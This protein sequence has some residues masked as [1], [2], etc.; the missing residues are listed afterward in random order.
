MDD[1]PIEAEVPA[2]MPVRMLNEF[3]YCPRLCFIEWVA[4]TFESNAETDEGTW[5]HR[6][7]DAQ[8]KRSS[9]TGGGASQPSDNRTERSVELASE[10]LGLTAKLDTVEFEGSVATPVEHKRGRP[11]P[12]ESGVWP[13]E[14]VQLCAQ[15]LLLREAGYVCD[16]G[17]VWFAQGRKRVTIAFDE[18]LIAQTLAA[19]K[20]AREL[21]AS[22]TMPPPL[23]DSPKC[24]A[25]SLVGTCLPD[26]T[27]LLTGAAADPPRMLVARDDNKRP[28]YVAGPVANLGKDGMRLAIRRPDAPEDFA[29]FEDLSTVS[30]FGRVGLSEA[31]LAELFRRDIPVFHF[32]AYGW[33]RGMSHGLPSKNVNVRIRQA[34]KVA[35]GDIDVAAEMI[36]GKVRNC[37]TQ[38]MRNGR[39]R[40]DEAL[41]ELKRL[42]LRAERA[43]SIESLLGYE[44]AA[45]RTYFQAFG[46]M[47]RTENTAFDF[48]ARNRR[49]PRDRVNALLS[50]CY[51]LLLKECLGAAFAAGLDPYMGVLHRPRFGRPALALDLQEEFRPVIADSVVLGV[52]NNEELKAGDFVDGGATGGILL[53]PDGRRRVMAAFERRMSTEV[54]HPFF[55]YRVTYRKVVALQA[56][57][58]A[59]VI[60]GEVGTYRAFC[61]R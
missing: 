57:L 27:N 5:V 56:R 10:K 14:M 29:R 18:D 3:A 21:A 58:F 1:D 13:P 35:T 22:G 60:T 19:I 11:A 45:A 46:S 37:R 32:S 16:E 44:G 53:S 36:S 30:V 42:R 9:P 26:E 24:P 34:L 47:I 7:V 8:R 33:L 61:T 43:Q 25:C 6:R 28:L 39:P 40:N 31:V 51:A 15:G 4:A 38:L 2:L 52:L 55:G 12:T 48:T 54:T 50:F 59:A 17:A 20:D 49:P 23:V 41:R